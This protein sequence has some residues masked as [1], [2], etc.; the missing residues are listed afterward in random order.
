MK[1]HTLFRFEIHA[2]NVMELAISHHLGIAIYFFEVGIEKLDNY[3][4][5]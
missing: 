2:E 4:R 5:A 1:P 3:H